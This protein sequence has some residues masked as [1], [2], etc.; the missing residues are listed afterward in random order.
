MKKAIIVFNKYAKQFNLK[1][2]NIMLKYHHT[3]RVVDYA[4]KIAE[5][6]KLSDEDIKLA[7]ISALLH[8]IARFYQYETY[9]TYYD[10]KSIDHGQKG[11]EILLE[12]NF[13]N[14]F[15]DYD[16]D[17]VL[18][19]VL[20][21]NKLTIASN[22]N[23]KTK[24]I[25]NIVRDADKIDILIEQGNVIKDLNPS[26]N[27]EIV[28]SMLKEELVKNELI[29]T[30]CDEILHNLAFIYD[31]NFKKTFEIVLET[32]VIENKINLL[33]IYTNED[34]KFVEDKLLFYAKERI[35]C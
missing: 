28:K 3:F 32:K 19:A 29:K 4:L 13:I 1:E 15:I 21:H 5:S 26:I 27:H 17:V 31:M 11:Y 14:E 16:Q 35:K 23:E 34:L 7:G 18:N 6:L 10:S 8:D 2:K 24:L 33:S 20:Y 9:Q 12:N 22:L 25:A 30:D